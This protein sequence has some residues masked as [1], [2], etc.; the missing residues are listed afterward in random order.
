MIPWTDLFRRYTLPCC[1]VIL[2]FIAMPSNA[3]TVKDCD[4]NTYPI[5]KAGNYLWTGENLRVRHDLD[6][7]K[8]EY[9]EI[10]NPYM[11]S[12]HYG[13]LYSWL[14]AMDSCEREGAQG[15][16]PAGWHIPSDAEWDSLTEWAGGINTAGVVLKRQGPGMFGVLMSGNYN[17][18]QGMDF[19]FG[20]EAY[21]W[22]STSFSLT[23]AW[24]RHF[25]QEV[26]NINRSTVQKHYHFSIRCV[27]KAE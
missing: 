8:L 18:I 4:G 10:I 19:Y 15:I 24:M 26:K 3:Q 11:D 1:M 17:P 23:A 7:K 27:R 12:S 25:G 6:G 16:C 13:L 9:F 20:E 22:S 5:M 2:P 14:T 21:F